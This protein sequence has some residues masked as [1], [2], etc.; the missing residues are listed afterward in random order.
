[1]TPGGDTMNPSDT[2][3][4]LG[5]GPSLRRW[6]LSLL[7][8][9][10]YTMIGC[11]SIDRWP[12]TEFL[13]HY[14]CVTDHT[15][16]GRVED[17][18]GRRLTLPDAHRKRYVLAKSLQDVVPASRT[19][20]QWVE[21]SGTVDDWTPD[22]WPGRV[23]NLRNT[24]QQLSIPLATAGLGFR[25]L[26]LLGVDMRDEFLHFYDDSPEEQRRRDEEWVALWGPD[27]P[28]PYPRPKAFSPDHRGRMLANLR[29]ILTRCGVVEVF[30]TSDV[31]IEGLA[32]AEM[33][34]TKPPPTPLETTTS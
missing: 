10:G 21:V 24:V 20:V 13:P 9:E 32:G 7:R 34:V 8:A 25:R 4:V 17:P 3:I 23:P 28:A 19:D 12:D 16:F 33:K 31:I 14:H 1:M 2:C 26:A 6:N 11:N 27:C 18:K 22:Q 5:N 30:T 15:Y 29:A